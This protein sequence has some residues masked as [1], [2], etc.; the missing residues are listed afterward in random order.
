LTRD[1]AE[2]KRST[3]VHGIRSSERRQSE[4]VSSEETFSDF[5]A[6]IAYSSD[7]DQRVSEADFDMYLAFETFHS[8]RRFANV[9]QGKYHRNAALLC[10]CL[11]YSFCP[12]ISNT[13]QYIRKYISEST[14]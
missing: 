3:E 14:A 10:K 13:M 8:P 11:S 1:I 7:V 9:S 2:R 6:Y 5:V 12:A 4:L